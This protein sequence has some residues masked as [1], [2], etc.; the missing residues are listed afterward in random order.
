MLRLLAAGR[1]Q[2][3]ILATLCWLLAAR[4]VRL[5]QL[6]LR[7]STVTQARAAAA[8][9]VRPLWAAARELLVVCKAAAVVALVVALTGLLAV[10]AVLAPAES[11]LSQHSSRRFAWLDTS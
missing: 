9:V 6:L 5:G 1:I 11:L 10:L 4:L 7:A 8:V 3:P 2:A